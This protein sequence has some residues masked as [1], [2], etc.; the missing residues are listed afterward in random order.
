MHKWTWKRHSPSTKTVDVNYKLAVS[1]EKLR[2]LGWKPKSLE[3]TLADGL[4][5]IEKAGLL[6][7]FC[8]M[9]AEE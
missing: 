4:G 3:D 8:R 9:T 7:Y 5:Y 6:P 1:S 2:N